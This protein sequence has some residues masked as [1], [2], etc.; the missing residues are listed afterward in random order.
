MSNLVLRDVRKSCGAIEV[1]KGID[2][3]AAEI[4]HSDPSTSRRNNLRGR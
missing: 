2:L 4:D 1:I 3:E